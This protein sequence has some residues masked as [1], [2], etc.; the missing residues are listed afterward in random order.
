MDTCKEVV[1][2]DS[3]ENFLKRLV[4]GLEDRLSVEFNISAFSDRELSLAYM[5]DR[6]IH[7]LIGPEDFIGY[8]KDLLEE[9][10]KT[11]NLS[12]A[13][14][15]KLTDIESYM[16]SD[17][18]VF[19]YGPLSS[20]VYEI[21]K[22]IGIKE[23][24]KGNE[25][26]PLEYEDKYSKNEEPLIRGVF[27]LAGH[28][29]RTA[30][31]LSLAESMALS[32]RV[33]Y[34]NLE[35]FI[36]MGTSFNSGRS[37]TLSDLFYEFRLGEV[38]NLDSFIESMNGFYFI[39]P[40]VCPEDME[41]IEVHDLEMILDMLIKHLSLDIIILELGA[42]YSK[43]LAI[44]DICTEIDFLKEDKDRERVGVFNNYLGR[45]T[46]SYL[47]DKIKEIDLDEG[48]RPFNGCLW[49][50]EQRKAWKEWIVRKE[51]LI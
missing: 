1:V 9:Y 8:I 18:G 4:K 35:V 25:K 15:I 34:L 47:V 17:D 19:K 6:N 38:E 41:T 20:L 13:R 5:K 24:K 30:Y 26:I 40:T 21:D 33:L 11:F 16:D 3:D 14:F 29:Y 36:S 43:Q 7:L 42:S 46:R 2:L 50:A 12:I 28:E 39:K 51:L 48:L 37:K 22:S 27:S 45:S 31:A 49:G 10:K 23:N 32:K 44:M